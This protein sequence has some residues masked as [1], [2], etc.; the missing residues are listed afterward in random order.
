MPSLDEMIENLRISFR[1]ATTADV[2]AS[3]HA[4]RPRGP[5]YQEMADELKVESRLR[6]VASRNIILGRCREHIQPYL[7]EFC[8]M[9]QPQALSEG[10]RDKH[11]HFATEVWHQ[12]RKT[13]FPSF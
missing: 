4:D 6:W 7:V 10:I 5:G 1:M 9:D 12:L 8:T 3:N 11:L 13:Y 2:P